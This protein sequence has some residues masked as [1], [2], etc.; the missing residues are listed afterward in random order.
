MYAC[1]HGQP[2]YLVDDRGAPVMRAIVIIYHT[3]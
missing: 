3:G 1:A 2:Q